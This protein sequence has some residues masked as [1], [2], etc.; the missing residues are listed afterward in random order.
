[1][2]LFDEAGALAECNLPGGS[3]DGLAVAAATD[4]GTLVRLAAGDTR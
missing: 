2:R 3:N 4:G 1:M